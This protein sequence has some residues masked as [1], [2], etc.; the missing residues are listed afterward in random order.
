MYLNYAQFKSFSD[1]VHFTVASQVPFIHHVTINGKEIYF[2]H[3]IGFGEIM[4]Y[5]IELERSIKEK[6]VVFNRFRDQIAFTDRIETDPQS[7]TFPII[8]LERTNIFSEYPP[9]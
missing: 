3:Q 4:V 6:Y 7:I 5:Y 8:E 1:F 2:V 9:K